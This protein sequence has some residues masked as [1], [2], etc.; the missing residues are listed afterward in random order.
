MRTIQK[1]GV[2]V[3]M[4]LGF[5]AV[6]AQ[7]PA[8]AYQPGQTISFSVKFEGHDAGQISNVSAYASIPKVPDSQPGFQRD[9]G[10][11]ESKQIG[12]NTFEFSYT[13]PN[14]QASGDYQLGSITAILGTKDTIPLVYHSPGEF[15]ARGFTINN[16]KIVEKPKIK[17]AKELSTP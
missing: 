15:L 3:A 9:F 13:I 4:L 17:E 12:P 1:T 11:N 8:P 7:T 16:P 14:N 6:R 5:N 2:L 10:F